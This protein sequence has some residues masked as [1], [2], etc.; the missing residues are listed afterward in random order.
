MMGQNIKRY[1]KK[2]S[3]WGV[4]KLIRKQEVIFFFTT[5]QKARTLNMQKRNRKQ[6]NFHSFT[7][8]DNIWENT[9]K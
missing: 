8:E 2:T 6:Q 1:I 3:T 9:G 7:I 5:R 4:L